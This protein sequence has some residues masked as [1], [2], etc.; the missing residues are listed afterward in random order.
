MDLS[1]SQQWYYSSGSISLNKHIVSHSLIIE[2]SS[3]N[4]GWCVPMIGYNISGY[5]T[6]QTLG[7]NGIYATSFT[8]AIL[9]L[10][11]WTHVAMTYST[12]NGIRLFVNG[13]LVNSNSHYLDYSASGN[14]ST[15]TVGTCLQPMTC[16]VGQTKIVPFQFH[17]KIDEMKIFSR[18]LS[19]SEV[20][21]LAQA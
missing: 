15:I 3:S 2:V 13:S 17:G 12:T 16:A 5:L 14:V 19:T 21:Q 7:S 11:Q 9:S 20:S 1:F 10:N 8:S 6:V 4:T 18:E